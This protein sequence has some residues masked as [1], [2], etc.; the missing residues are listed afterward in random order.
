MSGRDHLTNQLL[1]KASDG[2]LSGAE[3]LA[4]ASHL[5]QCENC[6]QAQEEWLQVS[7]RVES[8]VAAVSVDSPA[9]ERERLA[10]NLAARTGLDVARQS[11]E[12]V[13]WRFG[14]AMAIAATLALGILVAPRPKHVVVEKES[15]VMT[16]P[17]NAFE[18]D[19]E[20]F[21]ALPYSNPDLPMSASRIV[22]M[23]V[24]ISSLADVGIALEPVSNEVSGQDRSV[25]ADV[26]I[27]ADGQPVGVHGLGLE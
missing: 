27:G 4:A 8:L 24:P 10:A 5:A 23:Q 6:R 26:L 16:T 18:V 21:V 12:K 19:G 9:G 2:E 15:S 17:A 11:S 3:A 7:Q 22:Q 13:M 1:I 25:L 14:W 20:S